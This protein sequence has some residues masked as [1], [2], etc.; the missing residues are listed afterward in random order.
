MWL[1][2]FLRWLFG[3]L[4]GFG[5]A[6]IVF[7]TSIFGNYIVTLFLPMITI[8]NLHREWREKMDRAITF[9]MVIPLFFLH[10][11]YGVKVRTSGDRIEYEQPAVVIM[12]H[13]TRLD[14]LY[15]WLALWRIN[16]W[17]MTSN[18]IALKEL[19]KHVPGAGFGMQASQYVFMKR[20]FSVDL[21][22]LSRAVNYYA[23]MNRP[24]QILMFPEGTDRTQYTL[25]RSRDY[26]K[27]YNLPVLNNV[28]YPRSSGFTHLISEMRKKNYIRYVYD[29]TVAYP[30]EIVQNETDMILKGR[31]SRNV[32]YHIRKYEIDDLPSDEDGLGRWLLTVWAEKEKRLE[33]FYAQKAKGKRKFDAD[34]E[35]NIWLKDTP[36]QSFVKIF[37]FCFWI[38]VTCIWLYHLTFMPFVRCGLYFLL[39]NY[40]YIY[41]RYGGI[42]S[43]IYTRYEQWANSRR[44]FVV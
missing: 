35:M 21:P 6:G 23:E 7:L 39:L 15:F 11:V 40:F 44:S 43:L 33:Q 24:Y 14:W 37:G 16:P 34:G 26:A 41:V 3:P 38:T 5:F 27:K 22:R 18:K 8:F 31:L 29:V 28:L 19:L 4:I 20:D 1:S 36:R 12:N 2:S 30:A 13:R 10:Y 32:H 42:D 17:L 9:W 25:G